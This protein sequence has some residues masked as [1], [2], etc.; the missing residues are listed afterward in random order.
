MANP[1]PKQQTNVPARVPDTTI[2]DLRHLLEKYKDQIAMALPKH[3]TAERMMRVALTAFSRTPL[4]AKCSATSICGALVQASILGL[5]PDGMSGEAFLIPYW[6]T[7]AGGYECQMQAGYKGIV[8]LAR[9]TGEISLIDAQPV[10]ENDFFEFQKG[11]DTYWIHK[12]DPRK[13]RGAIYGYWAGY[14]LKDGGRNFEFMSVPEIEAH[15]DQY[16]QGAYKK[17]RGQFV[18]DDQQQKILTGPWADSPDWMF[19]KTPLMQCLKLAPKSYQLRTAMTLSETADA[20]TAQT[21]V[22]IPKEL[23]A[24]PMEPAGDDDE[25]AHPQA[26]AEPAAEGKPVEQ[27]VLLISDV[28]ARRLEQIAEESGW[29]QKD[30]LAWLKAKYLV[31][32]V[33]DIKAVDYD[34]IIEVIRAG[35]EIPQ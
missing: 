18:L 11:S 28:Q 32:A 20:G 21:F 10:H 35:G 25:I 22:D 1:N 29:R 30:M 7:K 17:S 27:P 2:N 3:I 34:H 19:R 12:W 23:A 24:V 31:A 8:K 6:N 13:E 33:S 14:V 16:S 15:R 5:E 4:L 26:K 9:N